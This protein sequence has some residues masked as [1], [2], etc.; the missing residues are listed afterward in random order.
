MLLA[1]SPLELAFIEVEV[2]EFL[3]SRIAHEAEATI[4]ELDSMLYE[5]EVE[6]LGLVIAYP[7]N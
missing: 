2:S 4:V 3:R 1:V 7:R 6:H 5:L